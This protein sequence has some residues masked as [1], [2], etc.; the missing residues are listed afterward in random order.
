MDVRNPTSHHLRGI[1][2]RCCHER[3][4]FVGEG[5]HGVLTAPALL[6]GDALGRNTPERGGDGR[7]VVQVE[8]R[9]LGLERL[10]GLGF[11]VWGLG[12]RV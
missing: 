1:H 3:R 12:F 4:L 5:P 10:P 6:H 9:I 8:V 2:R 11:R 7:G